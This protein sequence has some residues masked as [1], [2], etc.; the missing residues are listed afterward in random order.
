MALNVLEVLLVYMLYFEPD[1]NFPIKWNNVSTGFYKLKVASV[2]I[3]ITT[4]EWG[5]FFV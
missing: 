4:F 2:L 1:I 3:I 5:N